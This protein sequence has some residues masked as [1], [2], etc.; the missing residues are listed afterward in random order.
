MLLEPWLI[1]PWNIWKCWQKKK[2]T[3]YACLKQMESY[4]KED[5]IKNR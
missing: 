5:K 1:I 3:F 4:K 2:N